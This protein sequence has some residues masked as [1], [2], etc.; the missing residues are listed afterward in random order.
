M[1]SYTKNQYNRATTTIIVLK[2]RLQENL[3]SSK[4]SPKNSFLIL[5]LQNILYQNQTINFVYN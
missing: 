5:L 2:D 1:P 4:F 3:S